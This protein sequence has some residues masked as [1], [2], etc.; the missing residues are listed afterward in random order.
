LDLTKIGFISLAKEGVAI[1]SNLLIGAIAYPLSSLAKT[2]RTRSR[3]YPWAAD[4][5]FLRRHRSLANGVQVFAPRL[6]L[7]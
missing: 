4:E 5:Q 1:V 7:D 3:L 6:T 2:D